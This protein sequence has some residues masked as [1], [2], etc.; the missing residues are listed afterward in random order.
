MAIATPE[1]TGA[2]ASP[3][4]ISAAV[5]ANT[6]ALR[7]N[8]LRSSFNLRKPPATAVASATTTA[9][10][11]SKYAA[12]V[13][14]AETEDL[15]NL[16]QHNAGI[17]CRPDAQ[18][19]QAKRADDE[20]RRKLQLHRKRGTEAAMLGAESSDE[21]EGRSGLGKSKRVKRAQ[22]VPQVKDVAVVDED[23]KGGQMEAM[24]DAGGLG[25]GTSAKQ[26]SKKKKN[27]K[28]KAAAD[29]ARP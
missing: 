16:P 8:L 11:A 17:G 19:L 1:P 15:R 6:A 22:P 18:A 7:T 9:T 5:V 10:K 27:K 24:V 28:N 12:K 29:C 23:V 3:A 14:A 13:R 26:K 20:L 2:P 25:V 4:A 21:D